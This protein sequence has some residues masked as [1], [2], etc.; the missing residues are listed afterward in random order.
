L[1]EYPYPVVKSQEFGPG[2]QNSGFT[3]IS[4]ALYGKGEK[5]FQNWNFYRNIFH[6]TTNFAF[7]IFWIILYQ[8]GGSE[9]NK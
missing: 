1:G 7:S 3:T 9:E 2:V 8:A 4:K 5:S 6:L